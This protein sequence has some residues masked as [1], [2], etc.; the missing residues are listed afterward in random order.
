MQS[1]FS[2]QVKQN[3]GGPRLRQPSILRALISPRSVTRLFITQSKVTGR[4][5]HACTKVNQG[6]PAFELVVA[7]SVK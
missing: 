7:G 3:Q 6:D 2:H 1:T 4:A 5:C